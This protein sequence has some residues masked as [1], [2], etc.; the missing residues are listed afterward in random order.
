MNNLF[1]QASSHWVKYSQ[2]EMKKADDGTRHIKPAKKA[3]PIICDPLKDAEPMVVDALNVGLL[4]M[5]RAGEMEIQKAV[6][7]FIHKYGLLGFMTALPTT[8][9]FMDYDAAYL[10]KNHF[11][12]EESMSVT[13]YAAL[14]FPFEKPE[15]RKTKD[16]AR[17]DVGGDNDMIALAMTFRDQPM[18]LNMSFQREYSERY[19]WLLTLFKDWSFTFLSSFMYYEDYDKIDEPQR[20]LYRRGMAAFGGIA[21]TYHIALLDKPTIV[22][23]F[24]SLLLGIQMMFSF[25]LTDETNPLRACRHCQKAFIAGHPNAAFCTPQ[26]KN[27][28]NVYKSRAKKD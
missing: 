16:A 5:R 15:F 7:A 19:D 4:Q 27:Q 24:H 22:W 3:K 9:N 17:F 18:A 13:D 20:D 23:D 12:K 11:I 10:P 14:F 1:Q 25:M 6:M 26:C 2:Y 8:P 21:P 28:Y